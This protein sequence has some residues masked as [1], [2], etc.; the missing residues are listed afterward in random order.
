MLK[1]QEM[2][3]IRDAEFQNEMHSIKTSFKLISGNKYYL[4]E[5]ENGKNIFRL[6]LQMNGMWNTI[7]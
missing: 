1:K 7:F 6:Y 3:I 2:E 5:K 4:Y